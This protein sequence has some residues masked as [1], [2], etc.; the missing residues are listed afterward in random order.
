MVS[1]PSDETASTDAGM[2]TY[3][4]SWSVSGYDGVDGVVSASCSVTSPHSFGVGSEVVTC[5]S[6]DSSGNVGQCS[7]SVTVSDDE[8]PVLTCPSS[9][10]DVESDDDKTTYAY[11]WSASGIDNVDG[12]VSVSCSLSSP[13]DFPVGTTFVT[14]SGS[15]VAGNAGN[16]SFS[17]HVRDHDAPNVTACPSGVSYAAEAGSACRVVEWG[18]VS[19]VDKNDNVM[20]VPSPSSVPSGLSNGSSFCVGVT[21]M[22]YNFTEAVTGLWSL[23]TFDVTIVDVESPVLSCPSSYAGVTDGGSSSLLYSWSANASDIVDGEVSVSCS[24]SS[25]SSFGVGSSDVV[26]SASDGA[27]NSANCSF[28]VTVSGM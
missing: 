18:S 19:A 13:Y 26:C 1:C 9:I 2:S 6:S 15:D 21:T 3:A 24:P 8:A 10:A 7:F 23:C 28:S 25:P 20:D 17:V 12:S 11:S 14:C 22:T 27:G 16:C 4:Y 5:S